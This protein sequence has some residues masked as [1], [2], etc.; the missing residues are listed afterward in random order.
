MTGKEIYNEL[1]PLVKQILVQAPSSWLVGSA[2][3]RLTSGIQP[4]DYDILV[5]DVK[6][7]QALVRE[8]KSQIKINTFGGIKIKNV[9]FWVDTLSNYL[10]TESFSGGYIYNLRTQ[11]L[12][13][14]LY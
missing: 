1:P 12:L 7:Y 10:L 11:K 13:Q 2:V 14:K 9:D 4:R 6:E 5:T 3:E 8:F